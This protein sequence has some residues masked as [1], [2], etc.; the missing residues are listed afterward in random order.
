[1]KIKY[2]MKSSK[3]DTCIV[4]DNLTIKQVEAIISFL[5]NQKINFEYLHHKGD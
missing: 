4:L 5:D 3:R 2:R 1:M